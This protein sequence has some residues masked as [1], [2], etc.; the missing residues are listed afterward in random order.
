[1]E[2]I[3]VRICFLQRTQ[4]YQ[5]PQWL[6][7]WR[8][9]WRGAFWAFLCFLGFGVL[10]FDMVFYRCLTGEFMG[11][12]GVFMWLCCC[13]VAAPCVHWM[14]SDLLAQLCFIGVLDEESI[15]RK[16]TTKQG[17]AA[18]D[19]ARIS[20][21]P[22]MISGQVFLDSR[23][24]EYYSYVLRFIILYFAPERLSPHVTC[25]QRQTALTRPI[26][27]PPIQVPLH[28]ETG[29]QKVK[30]VELSEDFYARNSIMTG[31]W[32]RLY[33]MS[34]RTIKAY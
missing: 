30:I 26:I 29:T 22:R 5:L 16:P 10:S 28:T 4:T 1:M 32:T 8:W 34:T 20:R 17:S 19:G 6:C 9:Q 12:V 7:H 25:F 24:W 31:V 11:K 23:Y 27:L 3:Y 18:K 14:L 15:A 33:I 21:V 2:A 13:F